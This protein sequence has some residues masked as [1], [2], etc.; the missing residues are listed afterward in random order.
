M[1]IHSLALNGQDAEVETLGQL[2]QVL[3]LCH[4]KM[5]SKKFIMDYS[6]G[7][8]SLIKENDKRDVVCRSLKLSLGHL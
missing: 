7:G 1:S 8:S 2:F 4:I 5:I 3:R 6:T